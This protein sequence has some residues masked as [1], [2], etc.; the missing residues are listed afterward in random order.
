VRL[1]GPS[2]QCFEP[3]AWSPAYTL[4]ESGG[5]RRIT[6]FTTLRVGQV[7]A[8]SSG[9]PVR[10]AVTLVH[11]NDMARLMRERAAEDPVVVDWQHLS[12]PDAGV[13]P[14]SG[15]ALGQIV[16]AWVDGDGLVVVPALTKRGVRLVEESEGVLWSS[17]SFFVGDV[18]ARDDSGPVVASAQMLA[19]TL[20]PRPAQQADR[21]SAVTLAEASTSMEGVN[22]AD[23]AEL[24]DDGQAAD[25]PEE[26]DAMIATLREALAAAEA[27]IAELEGDGELSE[28]VAAQSAAL[29]EKTTEVTQLTEKVNALA[30][31]LDAE[32]AKRTNIERD[33]DIDALLAKG[34]EPARR[35]ALTE[36]W[37]SRE[38]QPAVW[39]A[40]T[41][42]TVDLTRHGTNSSESVEDDRTK[43]ARL[44][45]ERI[46]SGD[47]QKFMNDIKQRDPAAWALLVTKG[48]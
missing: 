10:P 28:S 20:T 11:L 13:G 34:I 43:R 8:R 36:A 24:Q 39:A 9:Q 19:V 7:S 1:S 17:P 27:R 46:A 40:L 37:A 33:R 41:V 48:A 45:E 5:L 4:G 18:H 35:V 31:A 38:S 25:S 16:D 23:A 29:T 12:E 26:K 21:I 47:P 30:I 42:P 32:V 22:M 3:N 15:G 14:E 2:V 6:P 44:C